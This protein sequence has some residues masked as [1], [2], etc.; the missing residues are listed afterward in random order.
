MSKLE[1]TPIYS[2]A[3]LILDRAGMLTKSRPIVAGVS[4]GVD[5]MVMLHCLSHLGYALHVVHINYHKRGVASDEDENLVKRYATSLNAS[6]ATFDIWP[7]DLQA[8]NFQDAAR[9]ARHRIYREEMKRVDAQG[10]ALGHNKLDRLETILMRILRGSAPSNWDGIEENNPPIVR[11]LLLST[12]EEIAELALHNN[13]PWREDESNAS[14]HYA[15]NLLRNDLIPSMDTLLPGWKQNIERITEYGATY[16]QAL[17]ALLGVGANSKSIS[18][19]KLQSNPELLKQALIHRFLELNGISTGHSTIAEIVQ[20]ID[21]QSGKFIDLSQELA[22]FKEGDSLVIDTRGSTEHVSVQVPKINKT[23]PPITTPIGTFY[24]AQ[25]DSIDGSKLE[26]RN[27]DA[28][29]TLRTWN[30]G[31]RIQIESGGSKKI[32]D[33]I[34]D[35]KIPL[36][37]KSSVFVLTLDETI[38]ACIF[39]HPGNPVRHRMATDWRVDPTSANSSPITL[40]LNH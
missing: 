38:I 19:S 23:T 33:L 5:S 40:F 31:D 18:I 27:P 22:V 2:S 3:K 28:P 20:L 36:R 30:Y 10:I 8:G 12:R 21:S 39:A 37:L 14:S 26:L 34:T 6:V 24:G 25:N 1:S 7:Q 4:G 32:S 35:W 16:V 13:I 15:R 11:P 9:N 29:I 17:D